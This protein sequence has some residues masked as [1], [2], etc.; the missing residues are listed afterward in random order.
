MNQ[1]LR[2]TWMLSLVSGGADTSDLEVY[3]VS[4]GVLCETPFQL[5]KAIIAAHRGDKE[6]VRRLG[7]M[8]TAEGV[9]A[10]LI[11][12]RMPFCWKTGWHLGCWVMPRASRPRSPSQ[13]GREVRHS[14]RISPDERFVCVQ[15]SIRP[16]EESRAHHR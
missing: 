2:I 4:G 10:V 13:C 5:R 16:H 12:Q 6:R 1:I 3:T 15:R 8:V 7:C 11:N 14:S 9:K